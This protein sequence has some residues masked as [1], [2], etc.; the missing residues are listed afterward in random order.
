[1]CFVFIL[2]LLHGSLQ[3][4]CL[5]WLLPLNVCLHYGKVRCILVAQTEDYE[6]L[7]C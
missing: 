3:L 1:M 5:Y 4:L 2:D 7:C 6:V